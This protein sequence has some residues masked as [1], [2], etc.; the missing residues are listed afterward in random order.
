MPKENGQKE[1]V[2]SFESVS[3]NERWKQT[4]TPCLSEGEGSLPEGS[5]ENPGVGLCMLKSKFVGES[6]RKLASTKS[7]TPID[8]YHRERQKKRKEFISRKGTELIKLKTCCSVES[9]DW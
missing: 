1:G 8:S 4:S 9:K 6:F 3:E 2:S 7:N 5:L